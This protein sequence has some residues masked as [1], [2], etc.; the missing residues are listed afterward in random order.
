MADDPS[1]LWGLIATAHVLPVSTGAIGET[2]PSLLGYD[3][4]DG[5]TKTYHLTVA[6]E[7]YRTSVHKR[8]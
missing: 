4:S 6:T 5:T 7:G 2:R 3:N 1:L 8:I